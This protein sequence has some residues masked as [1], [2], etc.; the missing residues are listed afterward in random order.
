MHI[1][2][3]IIPHVFGRNRPTVIDDMGILKK[4]SLSKMLVQLQLTD[5]RYQELELVDAL[6]DMVC[7]S[8]LDACD[9]RSHIAFRTGSRLETYICYDWQR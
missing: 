6:G 4:V 3:R 7:S 9:S 5:N 8:L 1:L 2:C